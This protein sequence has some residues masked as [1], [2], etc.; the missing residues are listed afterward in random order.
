MCPLVLIAVAAGPVQ[1]REVWHLP[2]KEESHIGRRASKDSRRAVL[3]A[4]CL[5]L[6]RRACEQ[7]A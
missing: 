3:D 2:P 5:T 6:C 7:A 4:H 1:C